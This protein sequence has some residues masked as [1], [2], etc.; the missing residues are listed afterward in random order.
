SRTCSS[1]MMSI[2]PGIRLCTA[3]S[4]SG[5]VLVKSLP[6]GVSAVP[7]DFFFCEVIESLACQSLAPR[8][9]AFICHAVTYRGILLRVGDPFN[10]GV[11]EF[12]VIGYEIADRRVSLC[13][14]DVPDAELPCVG[15]DRLRAHRRVLRRLGRDIYAAIGQVGVSGVVYLGA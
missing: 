11:L 2:L 9:H 8:L 7:L 15:V 6:P 1:S 14:R 4:A 13:D 10:A 12:F 3:D 5:I